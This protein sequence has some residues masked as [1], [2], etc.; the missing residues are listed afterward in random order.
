[1]YKE[2]VIE[3]IKTVVNMCDDIEVFD[4]CSKCPLKPF[5]QKYNKC[6][7]VE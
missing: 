4:Y 7:K 6:R 5:C 1:M 3:I 2:E